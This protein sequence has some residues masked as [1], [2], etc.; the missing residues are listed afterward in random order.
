MNTL[1]LTTAN[2]EGVI[3]NS[4]TGVPT[5]LQS[6][7][8]DI[9][10]VYIAPDDCLVSY[11]DRSYKTITKPAKKGDIIITLYTSSDYSQRLI[12]IKNEDFKNKFI[13]ESVSR[14]KRACESRLQNKCCESCC[15]PCC[16]CE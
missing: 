4:K 11:T 13:E 15:E 2:R 14:E 12:I 1:Y 9:N 10:Y 6:K 3:V 5:V 16:D 8:S 7:G